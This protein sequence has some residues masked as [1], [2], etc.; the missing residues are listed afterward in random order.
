[1]SRLVNSGNRGRTTQ[2]QTNTHTRR[3]DRMK[4]NLLKGSFQEQTYKLTTGW[5]SNKRARVVSRSRTG[6]KTTFYTE[7]SHLIHCQC[8]KKL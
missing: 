2:K 4:G 6:N 7:C 5:Q 1:M 3:A 8:K